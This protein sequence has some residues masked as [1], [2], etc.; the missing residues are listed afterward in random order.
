MAPNTIARRCISWFA[1][2]LVFGA[3]ILPFPV[4]ASP[5]HESGA[6]RDLASFVASVVDGNP[7]ELRGVY[8]QGMMFRQ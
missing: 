7:H 5:V 3:A 2:L 4:S 6:V 1:L 8:A